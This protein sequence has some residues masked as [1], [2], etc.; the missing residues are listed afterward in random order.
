LFTAMHSIPRARE[1][2]GERKVTKEELE[3]LAR[4][5]REYQREMA[6]TDLFEHWAAKGRP[7]EEVTNSDINVT[8]LSRHAGFKKYLKRHRR[9]EHAAAR[10]VLRHPYCR[11]CG[12]QVTATGNW[13]MV[14]DEVW[15]ATGLGPENGMLCL[16][17]L[18][19]RLGRPLRLEDF[20]DDVPINREGGHL[21]DWY[22]TPYSKAILRAIAAG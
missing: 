22:R 10:A 19:R 15:A 16:A 21:E 17:D 8:E 1:L 4:L 5:Y 12:L 20:R 13:Y 11:D 14:H 18:R 6:E 3:L 2:R 7:I 9:P